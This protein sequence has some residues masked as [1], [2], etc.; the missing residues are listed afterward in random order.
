MTRLDFRWAG[1]LFGG[2]VHGNRWLCLGLS[3]VDEV[4]GGGCWLLGAQVVEWI[5][6]RINASERDELNW[7]A[8][9][10][11]IT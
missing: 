8:R 5:K 6:T 7:C 3:F 9:S 1:M 4:T 11:D 2:A 10:R